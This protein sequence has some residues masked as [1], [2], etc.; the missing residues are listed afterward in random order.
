MSLLAPTRWWSPS[1]GRAAAREEEFS[2]EPQRGWRDHDSKNVRGLP[3]AAK[4]GGDKTAG[5]GG[6]VAEDRSASLG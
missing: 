1:A 2:E 6:H 3:G 4:G 5:A